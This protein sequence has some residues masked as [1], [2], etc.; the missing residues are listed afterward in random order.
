MSDKSWVSLEG[1]DDADNFNPLPPGGYICSIV[2]A[3]LHAAKSS[4]NETL[5]IEIDIA[6]GDFK[7]F[8]ANQKARFKSDSWLS[9]ARL[10]CPTINQNTGKIHFRLKNFLQAVKDSN[11]N[12]NL[13]PKVGR[14]NIAELKG[15]LI[16][17]VFGGKEGNLKKDGSG[18]YVNA[19]ADHALPTQKIIDEDFTIPDIK[20]YEEHKSSAANDI[21]SGSPVDNKDLP[22]DASDTPF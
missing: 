13:D 3:Y 2:N 20:P 16:G 15:K 22:F 6:K 7:N 14:F 17:V 19:V 11:P 8:F 1:W 9:Y 18:R 10:S 12:L 5:Y 21:F 4:G